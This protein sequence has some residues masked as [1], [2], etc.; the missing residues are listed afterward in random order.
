MPVT[1]S[2]SH[3]VFEFRLEELVII[4]SYDHVG[5]GRRSETRDF[6][7]VVGVEFVGKMVDGDFVLEQEKQELTEVLRLGGLR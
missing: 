1:E 3:L 2:F 4:R 6:S 7:G 5:E